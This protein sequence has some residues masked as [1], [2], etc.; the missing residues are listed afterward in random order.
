MHLELAPRGYALAVLSQSP[1]RRPWLQVD[2]AHCLGDTN[3]EQPACQP[4]PLGLAWRS[5]VSCGHYWAA[6]LS[7][8]SLLSL[9][10]PLSLF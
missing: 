1:T 5:S 7:L 8:W 9:Q 6:L 10:C 2:T 3:D 4:T